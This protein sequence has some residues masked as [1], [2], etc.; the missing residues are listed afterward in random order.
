MCDVVS[1]GVET[2]RKMQENIGYS[3]NISFIQIFWKK[4]NLVIILSIKQS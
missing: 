3:G 1:V 4:N 2:V